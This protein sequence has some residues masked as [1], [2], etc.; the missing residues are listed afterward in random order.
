MS[1]HIP[2]VA[3][4]SSIAI[5]TSSVWKAML[6]F[7]LMVQCRYFPASGCSERRSS[8]ESKSSK[9]NLSAILQRQIFL[10]RSLISR[11]PTTPPPFANHES[12]YLKTTSRP[13]A[14]K[15]THS[16][17]CQTGIL[18]LRFHFSSSSLNHMLIRIHESMMSAQAKKIGK[19]DS[20]IPR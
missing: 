11:K 1:N 13:A 3:F 14:K 18:H 6:H 2:A 17:I 7:L 12:G 4:R 10:H 15:D 8:T 5:S 20:D 9:P 16:R 19:N